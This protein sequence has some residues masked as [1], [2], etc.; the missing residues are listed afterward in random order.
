MP[1]SKIRQYKLRYLAMAPETTVGTPIAVSP[2]TS[3]RR[4]PVENLTL[5]QTEGTGVFQRDTINDGRAAAAELAIGSFGDAFSFDCEVHD[6]PETEVPYIVQLLRMCGHLCDADGT[7]YTITPATSPLANYPA[8]TP[9][10]TDLPPGTATM[11]LADLDGDTGAVDKYFIAAGCA[12]SHTLTIAGSGERIIFNLAGLGLIPDASNLWID[13]VDA[14]SIGSFIPG[15]GKPITALSITASIVGDDS[16][17]YEGIELKNFVFTQSA[18]VRAT[19]R[20][21]AEFGFGVPSVFLSTNPSV[22]FQLASTRADDAKALAD[23]A[24]G[25]FLDIT[26]SF[27]TTNST[28]ELNIPRVQFQRVDFADDNGAKVAQYTAFATRPNGSATAPYT[29]TITNTTP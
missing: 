12:A 14:K 25:Q 17:A 29:Y 19:T 21:Q 5:S 23:W 6:Q 7:E 13:A 3:Y 24:G 1:G 10:V 28:I 8:A 2:G 20:P 22:S 26:V 15:A 27:A 11:V 4:L 16:G 9:Y 18:E